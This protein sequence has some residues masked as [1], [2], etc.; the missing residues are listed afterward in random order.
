MPSRSIRIHSRGGGE[1]DCYLATPT[2]HGPVPAI[3]LASAVHGVDEDIRVIAD[4][5]AAQG[6]LATAPDLFWRSI[7]GPLSR[8]DPRAA[9]RAQPRLQKIGAGE[10]DMADTLAYL[11]ALPNFNGRAVAM[12]LCYGGP[13][14][15]TR[16][17]APRLCRGHL[18]PWNPDAGLRPRTQWRGRARLHNLGR[19]RPSGASRDLECLS[20]ISRA[21]QERGSAHRSGRSSRIHDAWKPECISSTNARLFYGAVVGHPQR[22]ARRLSARAVMIVV[23][24]KAVG[25]R[26]SR[27]DHPLPCRSQ[28][29]RT[30]DQGCRVLANR[31][32]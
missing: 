19:S 20:G 23:G 18:L 2:I 9:R 8:N 22:S 15:R 26:A 7:P 24:A 3:V 27:C 11:G 14:R 6:F 21:R 32:P 17:E 13:L 31:K 25:D 28:E 30:K 29:Q 16:A 12:G 1:F 10:D 4:E 5:F